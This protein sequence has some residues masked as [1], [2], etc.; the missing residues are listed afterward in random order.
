MRFIGMR[1]HGRLLL[2]EF[3]PFLILGVVFFSL[4]LVLGDIFAHLWQ[5][6]NKDVPFSQALYVSLLY[7]PKAVSY[8]LPIGAMFASAFSLGT[9]GARNELIAIF[10]SGVSLFRFVI[11][12]L[13]LALLMCVG[14]YFWEDRIVI[15]YMKQRSALSKELL[16]IQDP[17]T[18]SKVVLISDQGR[19]L[20]YADTYN[21]E[22]K[23]LTGL[24]VVLLDEEGKFYR[25]IDAEAGTWQEDTATW[26]LESCRVFTNVGNNEVSQEIQALYEDDRLVEDPDTFKIDTRELE[27]MNN[28]EALLWIQTQRRAGLPYRVHQSEL[29]QRYT[30]AFTPFL[31]VF[32]AGALGGRFRRNILL[33]SLLASLGLSSAWYIV[34]MLATIL[35][36]NGMITPLM[37]AVAPYLF[38]LVIG[39]WLFVYAKT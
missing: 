7:A 25:R 39:S 14:G 29:Y 9:L 17:T 15:P 13:I 38:F 8:A 37:G 5:Y 32:F 28:K 33:M 11:P 30:I 23:I 4:I 21:H 36:G 2:I 26:H 1:M 3:I 34:R 12:I 6:L 35:S 31:V 27:E 20:Y 19:I 18:R 22:N 10:G 16:D 24:T